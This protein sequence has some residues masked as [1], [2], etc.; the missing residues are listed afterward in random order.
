MPR[1]FLVGFALLLA[2]HP[3][4]MAEEKPALEP[5]NYILYYSFAF[6]GPEQALCMLKV[7]KKGGELRAEILDKAEQTPVELQGFTVNE[8]KV[9]IEFDLAGRKL[10]F[11]G[12]VTPKNAKLA[13]G[14][15]G[16]EDLLSRG[17][18]IATDK[19]KIEAADASIKPDVPES[20]KS[21]QK[22]T[23]AVQALQLQ[24]RRTK[25]DDTKAEL[26]KKL[27]TAQKEA[28]A[29]TP[30]LYR[31]VLDKNADS[32]LVVEAALGLLRNAE[33]AGKAD[34]AN[35]WVQIVEKYTEPYG[36]RFQLDALMQCAD[37]VKTQKGFSGI[38]ESIATKASKL[39][40]QDSPVSL[41]VRLENALLT[42]YEKDGKEDLAK[43]AKAKLT[44]LELAWDAEYQIKVPPF[45]PKAFAG[46]TNKSERA[47][48]LE[49]FTGAQCPPCVAA[50]VAFDALQKSYG[51]SDLVLIQ[52][53]MHIPGPDPLTSPAS[54]ARWKYYGEKFPMDLRGTPTVLFNG[55]PRRSGGGGMGGSEAK[56]KEYKR[57]IDPLLEEPTEIKLDGAVANKEGKISIKIDIHGIKQPGDDIK[58]RLLLVEESIKY[59]GGNSLRFHHQVVRSMPGGVEGT[60]LKE[61]NFSKTF[62]IDPTE[63]RTEL[64]KYLDDFAKEREFPK[65]ERPLDLKHL[66]VIALI[67]DDASREILQARQF[68]MPEVK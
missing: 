22:L 60:A 50:D 29:Q 49:L 15:F 45:K 28:E 57:Y 26:K 11:H 13:L 64:T 40:T 47:A 17:K 23:Q 16:D 48:V 33:Q 39:M 31:E 1:T 30:A 42:S 5:G 3:A 56:F 63:I 58:L 8:S 59:V 53:H 68:E 55:K 6:A 46:R 37:A 12:N 41:Q 10:A 67:Q 7:A 21:A 20:F 19:E 27:E 34:D 38:T 4:A 9:D 65:A 66:R 35:K 43:Q 25:N 54:E 2:L 36:K 44:K 62:E 51:P 18:F 52:Y 32:P 24:L 14:S 61:E